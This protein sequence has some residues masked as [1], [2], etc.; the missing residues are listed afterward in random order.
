MCQREKEENAP[1]AQGRGSARSRGSRRPGD[2]RD[3]RQ[4]VFTHRREY[5]GWI[6][7]AKREETRARRVAKAVEMLRKGV[8]TPG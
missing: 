7:E 3:V 1:T 4:L 6:E 2:A 8:K 5:V